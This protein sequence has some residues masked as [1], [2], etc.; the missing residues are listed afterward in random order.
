MKKYIK[1]ISKTLAFLAFLTCT[2]NTIHANQVF[3]ILRGSGN[4]NEFKQV[5]PGYDIK[6]PQ[7]HLAHNDFRIEW[8]YLTANLYDVKT[9]EH[10]GIQ[11]TLFRQASQKDKNPAN[12]P[13]LSEQF[14]M[15]H[16]AISNKQE[17][18]YQ[19]RFSRGGIGQAGVAQNKTGI[20]LWLDDWLWQSNNTQS[21]FPATLNYSVNNK[22]IQ[23]E[24]TTNNP[25]IFHGENGYSQKS[26]IKNG[27]ASASYY[28]TQPRINI[29]GT[30]Q[31]D[32]KTIKLK[33]QGWLDREWSSQP[34]AK[35]QQGWDWF[36]IQLESGYSLMI[37]RLRHADK[38]YY[39]SGTWIHPDGT[40]QTLT[41]KD[42]ILTPTENE[43]LELQQN[44]TI[45][46]PTKWTLVIPSLQKN[47]R[48]QARYNNQYLD[49]LFP[50]WEGPIV[51]SG[52][53][54]GEGY[55]EMMGYEVKD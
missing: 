5:K 44:R 31:Q 30:L 42:I 10:Y 27:K 36:S 32:E 22:H 7:D 33:G 26:P 25:W 18:V 14:W 39:H 50:Y 48:I 23:L 4:A 15:A 40:T 29:S 2:S 19:E 54:K 43:K 8:W 34:L 13:W 51:V 37:F 16:G 53:D 46:V 20:N 9:Q 28:Y 49:A 55:L 12:N 45:T 6:F 21:L 17:H 1:L 41:N 3:D 47:W 35:D 24:L 52:D 38:N 11:W